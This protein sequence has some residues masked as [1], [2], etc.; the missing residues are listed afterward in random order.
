MP[1]DILDVLNGIPG[2]ALEEAPSDYPGYRWFVGTFEQPAD[3][4]DPNGL[5]FAQR[6]RILHRDQAQPMVLFS[7]GYGLWDFDWLSEPALLTDANQISVEHRFFPPSRP[8]P[9]DWQLLTIEQAAADHHRLVEALSPVYG[10]RWLSTGNSKGGM[11]SIYHRRFYP[12]DID[13]TVAYVAPHSYG[14]TDSRYVT[15][16]DEV[17]D[18]SCRDAMKAFQ[19]DALSRRATLIDFV[20]QTGGNYSYWGE[21]AALDFAVS[22]LRWAVWQYG[23]ASACLSVPDATATDTEVFTYLQTY[24][25]VE[26]STNEGL[27][28]F[29][30]YYFQAAKQLGAPGADESYMAALLTVPLGLDVS[31]FVHPGPTKD[32]TF[33]PEAMPDVQSWISSSGSEL[34]FVYGENDPWTAGAFEL[35]NAFDSFRLTAP[36]ANH[37]AGIYQLEPGDLAVAEDAV[38]RWA[39]LFDSAASPRPRPAADQL[40]LA[41]LGRLI[42]GAS[43]AGLR[44]RFAERANEILGRIRPPR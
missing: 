9:A 19:V 34:L 15:F 4:D 8:E 31:A 26:G 2:M 29:E 39:G 5:V 28:F 37:G 41:R 42:D 43:N 10:A 20:F 23:D 14:R 27:D 35:G 12:A 1:A 7:T 22:G 21:D 6:I 13:G 25:P 24:A 38:L 36:E 30:P 17:G 3:H 16:L 18:P 44:R 40:E 33:Q 32:T 11:T